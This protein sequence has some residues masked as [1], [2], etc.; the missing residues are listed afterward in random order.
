MLLTSIQQANRFFGY[1]QFAELLHSLT[2]SRDLEEE[3]KTLRSTGRSA[4]VRRSQGQVLTS[5]FCSFS[6][7][8]WSNFSDSS[9]HIQSC[10]SL[11]LS[12]QETGHTSSVASVPPFRN[13]A[14]LQFVFVQ[15]VNVQGFASGSQNLLLLLSLSL[16]LTSSL[17]VSLMSQTQRTC[18]QVTMNATG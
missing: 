8:M 15:V 2:Q 17:L 16:F 12:L 18:C 13:A 9:W 5:Y 10:S 7:S 14:V 3:S 11:I 6:F 1:L 4:R